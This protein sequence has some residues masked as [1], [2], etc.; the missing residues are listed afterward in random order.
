MTE[1]RREVLACD[2]M[3]K[4]DMRL[5]ALVT[6][7]DQSHSLL[8]VVTGYEENGEKDLQL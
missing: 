6:L 3:I 1:I 2:M 4:T 5:V 7:Q 8:R